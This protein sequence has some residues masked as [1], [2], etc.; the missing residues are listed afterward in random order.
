MTGADFGHVTSRERAEELLRRG[1]LERLFLLPPQFGGEDVPEN[2]VYV[3]VGIADAK[4]R[5]DDNIIGPLVS[6]GTIRRYRAT[7]RYQGDSFVPCA[8]HIKASDPGEFSSEIAI[9]G[10]GLEAAP[11]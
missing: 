3:P 7:P 6:Q 10:D 8:I 4:S 5:I 11:R 2:V 9:W 1:Q